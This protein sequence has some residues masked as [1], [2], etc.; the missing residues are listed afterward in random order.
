MQAV[1]LNLIFATL[2]ISIAQKMSIAAVMLS[3]LLLLIAAAV[4]SSY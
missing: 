1:L 2:V 4:T 3:P